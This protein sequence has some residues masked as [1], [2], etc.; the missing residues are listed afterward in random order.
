MVGLIPLFAVETL[1]PR[2]CEQLQGFRRRMRWFIENRHDLTG[3]VACMMSPG[4]GERRLLSIVDPEQLRS[5][6]RVMLD[7][8]EFL[9]PYGIRGVSRVHGEHPYKIALDGN[10]HQVD[11]EPGES[12][13]GLFGGN[14]NWRGPVWFPVNFLLSSR[15]RN[16]ITTSAT[17]S[18]SNARLVRAA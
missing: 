2:I 15:Y 6:L 5:V 11:Y 7:E 16:S 3:N 12:T 10:V 9:S 18:K 13:S 14:S 17:I 4:E 1:E 8:R